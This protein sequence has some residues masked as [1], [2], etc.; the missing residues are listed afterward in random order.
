MN[1]A[2]PPKNNQ[3]DLL[4]QL[5]RMNVPVAAL[6]SAT[7]ARNRLPGPQLRPPRDPQ[8][9]RMIEAALRQS[10]PIDRMGSFPP[11]QYEKRRPEHLLMPQDLPD[12]D[13][14]GL[15]VDSAIDPL[16]PAPLRGEMPLTPGD[17]TGLLRAAK[18]V[19]PGRAAADLGSG[20]LDPTT[21]LLMRLDAAAPKALTFVRELFGQRGPGVRNVPDMKAVINQVAPSAK[22]EGGTLAVN[23]NEVDPLVRLLRDSGAPKGLREVE[24]FR[25]H[26]SSLN[27]PS[28]SPS[29][30]GLLSAGNKHVRTQAYDAE[31]ALDIV[32]GGQGGRSPILGG[33]VEGAAAIS[34]RQTPGRGR[35][36]RGTRPSF[37]DPDMVVARNAQA[38]NVG[39]PLEQASD[40]FVDF[41]RTRTPP[42]EGGTRGVDSYRALR[43][44]AD[45]G[46][47]H[48]TE[49]LSQDLMAQTVVHINRAPP[50]TLVQLGP[51][52][53]QALRRQL[54]MAQQGGMAIPGTSAAR[55]LIEESLR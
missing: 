29:S 30:R 9:L 41:L 17:V 14:H 26:W 52:N 42:A 37:Y 39:N 19:T 4:A 50:V 32:R 28:R 36:P 47:L 43:N 49:R 3:P 11:P 16:N 46:I 40:E 10:L 55:D 33:G 25:P 8:M 31:Q 18:S 6:S 15:T 53:L 7:A 27:A 48:E 24:D 1:H 45:Q 23:M 35:A 22:L 13:R 5:A 2:Y 38:Q 20:I 12:I 51:S 34:M 44:L 21:R 54:I